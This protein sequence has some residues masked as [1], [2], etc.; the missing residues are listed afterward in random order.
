MML[1]IYKGSIEYLFK[2]KE[3]IIG[4][5]KAGILSLLSFL[6]IPIFLLCGFSY[7]VIEIGFVGKIS[8]TNDPMP[9]LNNI[10]KMFIQGLKF[11]IVTF[12]YFIPTIIVVGIG[13]YREIISIDLNNLSPLINFNIGLTI[14]I[15]LILC[16]ISFMFTTTAIPHMVKNK[17]IIYAFKFKDLIKLIKY[18]SIVNYLIFFIISIILF[19]LIISIA[20][21]ASQF[22]N[23]AIGYIHYLIFSINLSFEVVGILN[24][25]M[26]FIFFLFL[27][28]IY[29]V[30]ESRVMS[31]MYN[32]DGL[33]N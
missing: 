10:K 33:E 26:F 28:G 13:L 12:I 23:A 25:L 5:T 3:N 2:N 32:E 16:F 19:D 27:M 31:F 17:S 30:I 20:Y 1:E 9:K 7:R 21:I 6:L 24:L 14:I 4:I 18:N 15:S 22:L 8:Y 11:L 29:F